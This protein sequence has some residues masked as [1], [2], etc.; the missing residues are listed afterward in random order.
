MTMGN[1]KSLMVICSSAVIFF[2]GFGCTRNSG[3]SNL[4]A[5][6]ELA[7]NNKCPLSLVTIIPKDKTIT[8]LMGITD[9]ELK[10]QPVLEHEDYYTDDEQPAHNVILTVPF[11]MSR[12]EITNEQFCEVMNWSM[13]KDYSSIDN[14]DLAGING[15]KYLGITNLDGGEGSYLNIQFGIQIQGDIIYPHEGCEQ[16]PVHGVAWYC[17]C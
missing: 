12:Y 16:Q 9:E 5:I 14:G 17:S 15:M 6:R 13:R 7:I 4:P 1:K 11:E 3:K 2:M 8:F 10:G